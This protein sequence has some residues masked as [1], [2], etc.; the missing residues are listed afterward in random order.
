MIIF[1][2]LLKTFEMHV[3]DNNDNWDDLHPNYHYQ[4]R[5]KSYFINNMDCINNNEQY[6]KI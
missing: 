5:C 6:K 3:L 4:S 2:L 1:E